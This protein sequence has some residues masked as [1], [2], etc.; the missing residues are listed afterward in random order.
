[1]LKYLVDTNIIS[2]ATKPKPSTAILDKLQRHRHE[3]GICVSIWHELLFGLYR[4]P[5]SY[6]R[7]KL[8][9]YL[10]QV[11]HQLPILPYDLKAAEWY[12]QERARL[13]RM[14]RIP[15][16]IDGQIAAMAKVNQL[17]LVTA[18]VSD[19]AFFEGIA[20]ENWFNT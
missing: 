12:A 16:F 20:I 1:M 17:I 8:E 9:R 3:M 7:E 10:Y 4:L 19:Y 5:A 6:K 14:G 18:N 13:V 11:V 15:P 2:E